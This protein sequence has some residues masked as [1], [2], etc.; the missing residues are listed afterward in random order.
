MLGFWRT[1][2]G[3]HPMMANV[4]LTHRAVHKRERLQGKRRSK[5]QS[6]MSVTSQVPQGLKK[7]NLI[8]FKGT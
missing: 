6:L 4:I 2:A 8:V 5:G 7:T 3:P 1:H